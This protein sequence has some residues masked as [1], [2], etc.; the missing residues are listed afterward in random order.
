MNGSLSLAE[1]VAEMLSAEIRSGRLAVGSKLPTEVELVKQL[2]VSRTVVRE[3]VSRMRSAGLVESRQGSGVYVISAEV[4]SLAFD[5]ASASTKAKVLQIAAVRRALEAEA[6]ALAA[7]AAGP[8]DVLAIR[9]AAQAL[10]DAVAQGGD[11]VAEDVAFHLV[12]AEATGNPF[13]LATLR[14]LSRFTAS[15]MRVTRANEARNEEFAADVRREH[16]AIIEAIAAGDPD[17]A[18]AAA[19]QHMRKAAER[20][21]AAD[22]AFWTETTGGR[23]EVADP[24]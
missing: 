20:I 18:R 7:E 23:V 11:G 8:E 24:A 14:Y 16:Q 12:I 1:Q 17:A 21:E 3:A 2:G 13:M 15:G 9:R 6:A 22:P 5:P 19:A 10:A 4:S